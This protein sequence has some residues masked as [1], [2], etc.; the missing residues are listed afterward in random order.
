MEQIPD[1]ERYF[2]TIDIDG[3]DPSLAP[4]TGTP[5]PGGF[6]YDEAN[7]LLENLAKKG[8]IVGFDLVEVSPPYDL[9]G[10]TSQVAARLIL[11]FAGFILKQRERE[12]DVAREATME[13]QA[14]RQGHA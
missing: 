8:K 13:V 5:S 1:A 9:S 7:E 4:G 11:D 3:M 2:V 14:S 12:G 6:S 10:I